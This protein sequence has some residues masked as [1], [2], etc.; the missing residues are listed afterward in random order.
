[1]QLTH[2]LEAAQIIVGCDE[3]DKRR[4]LERMVDA[5]LQPRVVRLNPSISRECVC[6]A[7]FGR[8]AGR[9]TVMGQGLAFPHARIK[10][11]NGIG[12]ALAILRRPVDFGGGAAEGVS[13]VCMI[14]VPQEA[15]MVT[16][17]VMSRVAQFFK[18]DA[19][20]AALLAAG[21]SEEVIALFASGDLSL[22]IPVTARDIMSPP[23]P[24]VRRETPLREVTSHMHAERLDAMP[25]V[26]D[27]GGGLV[28]EITSDGLFQFGLPEFFQHLKSVSFISEFDPFEKYFEREA[29]SVAGQLMSTELCRMPPEATLLEIVFALAV[30]RRAQV[31][32][33]DAGNTWVGTIDRASVLNNV[34]NW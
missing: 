27:A 23:G 2:H 5:L 9:P 21:R 4:L 26:E 14:V 30:K 15:P 24:R 31:Y 20:R 19:N 28:G 6:N 7:I 22:D 32:V 12:M 16:L 25:V 33:V 8:E 1:M 18:S 13:L 34:L 29:H 17:K 10:G 3:T 11:F